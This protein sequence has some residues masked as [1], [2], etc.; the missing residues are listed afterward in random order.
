[1]V[2]SHIYGLNQTWTTCGKDHIDTLKIVAE[3]Y[4][5][6]QSAV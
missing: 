6:P 4:L 2:S 5:V 1:M 3:Q